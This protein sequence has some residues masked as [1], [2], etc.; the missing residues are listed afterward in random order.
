MAASGSI[1]LK[2]SFPTG[3]E[4]ILAVTR[5][6]ARFRLGGIH[7]RADVAMKNFLSGL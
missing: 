5:S 7:E 4:K 6:G 1:P 2:N 3:D